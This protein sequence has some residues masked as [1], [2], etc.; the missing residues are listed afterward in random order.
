MQFDNICS[1]LKDLDEKTSV[2]QQKEQMEQIEEDV[3]KDLSWSLE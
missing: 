2:Q 3:L 1:Q